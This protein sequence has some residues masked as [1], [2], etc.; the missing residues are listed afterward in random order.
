MCGICGFISGKEYSISKQDILLKM[1]NAIR[2]RGP[3]DEGVFLDREAALGTRRLSIIDIEGGHQPMHN[4]DSSIWITYN[5]EI[6][7]FRELREELVQ[8]RHVFYTKTDTEVVIHAYEEFGTDCV[9]KLNGMFAFAIWDKRD[10]SLFLARDRFGIKPLYYYEFGGQLIFASEIKSIL[11][12]P[13]LS[14]ELDMVS[15]DQ[16]LTLEYVPAPRSIF[17]RI[18]KLP[19]AHTLAYK[20]NNSIINKYW[21]IDFSKQQ[22]IREEEA[23]ERLLELLKDSVKRQ[24]ISDVP[25]GVFLSGGIDSSTITAIASGLSANRLK[26]FSIGFKER[27]FDESKYVKQVVDLYHTEHYHKDFTI[28]E[29]FGLLP[30]AASLLDEPLGDASFLPTFLLSKFTREQVTVALSGDGGDEL[31]AGY[32][33]YQAHRLAS[34]YCRIPGF[35]KKGVI[36]NIVNHLPVS[37]DNFSLD[38]KAKKFISYAGCPVLARHISWMGSFTPQEKRE[39]CSPNFKEMLG[40]KDSLQPL[41]G[42]FNKPCENGDLNRLQYFDVKTY[43]QD[44]LLVKTD[45]ASMF[46]SLE[47][48]VPYLDHNIAEFVFS[49]P[50]NLRLH[51]FQTK[52]IL[53]K[54]VS[55]IVPRRIINRAKKGFG[56]PVGFWLKNELR[57]VVLEAL[58]K[59]KI[60]KEG[61]FNYEAIEGLL[62]QHTT[63]RADNRKKIWTLVMFELWLNNYFN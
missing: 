57:P 58:R 8:K 25:L 56:I 35:I 43:L 24:M 62:R 9:K 14:C 27:S 12:F 46:N 7:N 6:Y 47:V 36:E 10:N 32:P 63:N 29:L 54:A 13:G 50:T 39:L 11:R 26:T 28:K 45:R 60:E 15:L 37:M 49:L 2:H 51:N 59:D 41:A 31:F 40:E 3:D 44:D 5:G 52:Y 30:E 18:N 16:Y 23:K 61:L 4:E 48:R 33:T 22:F 38:F 55:N 20:D 53:K 17:K 34:Y 42:Y 21:D 19:A 1:L